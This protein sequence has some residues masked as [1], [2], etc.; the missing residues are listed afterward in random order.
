MYGYRRRFKRG[1][2]PGTNSVHEPGQYFEPLYGTWEHGGA[3]GLK[4]SIGSPSTIPKGWVLLESTISYRSGN[5]SRLLQ[6]WVGDDGSLYTLEYRGSLSPESDELRNWAIAS[7]SS[8]APKPAS[9][10]ETIPNESGE[11]GTAPP[12][13]LDPL[14]PATGGRKGG[15]SGSRWSE[16]YYKKLQAEYARYAQNATYDTLDDLSKSYQAARNASAGMVNVTVDAFTEPLIKELGAFAAEHLSDAAITAYLRDR[17]QITNP[18]A[19]S[20]AK[21]LVGWARRGVA[22]LGRQGIDTMKGTYAELADTIADTLEHAVRNPRRTWNDLRSYDPLTSDT[23]S[24]P[25][26]LDYAE[27]RLRSTRYSRPAEWE[28]S[29]PVPRS[30]A[31]AGEPEYWPGRTP[32][33]YT[34]PDDA[35]VSYRRTYGGGGRGAPYGPR[36]HKPYPLITRRRRR[37][38]YVFSY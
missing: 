36:F 11:P 14:D 8:I 12:G 25:K 6:R 29:R 35:P 5:K 30:S 19:V 27:S 18:V 24:D 16:D 1:S 37:S 38:A 4:Q 7:G 32:A 9:P 3:G 15:Q 10:P 23:F 26:T 34:Q 13:S 31:R 33:R 21:T 28:T 20:A 22:Y 17:W 2:A